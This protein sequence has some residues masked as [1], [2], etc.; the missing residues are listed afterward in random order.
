MLKS[1]LAKIRIILA[2]FGLL[3]YGTAVHAESEAVKSIKNTIG[4]T[5]AFRQEYEAKADAL[6]G[7][8]NKLYAASKF[9]EAIE[10]YLDAVNNYRKC[11][12]YETGFVKERVEKCQNQI[13]QNSPKAILE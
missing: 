2:L 13:Y 5:T 10:K 4:T 8:G 7:E 6:F 1:K 11:A 3:F 12:S 9:P